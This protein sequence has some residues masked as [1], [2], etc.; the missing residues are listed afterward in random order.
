MTSPNFFPPIALDHCAD[1]P[2]YQQLFDMF[3]TAILEGRLRPGQRVPSTRSLSVELMISRT[4][5]LTAYEQLRAEGYLETFLGS[6]TCVAR[7]FPDVLHDL[8]RTGPSPQTQPRIRRVAQRVEAM[9]TDVGEPAPRAPGAFRTCDPALDQLPTKVWAGLIARHA[10]STAFEIAGYG[11]PMG[12]FPL[13]QSIAAY[14]GAVRATSCDTS[15]IMIVSGSQQGLQ[16]TAQALLNSGDCVWLEDPGY[17]RAR[18]T[19]LMAG[20]APAPIPV[21]A[22]GL[23]V[24]AGVQCH[25]DACAAYVTPS[26]QN[27]TGVTMSAGRRLQLLKWAAHAGAWII[28]DDYDSE[29]RYSGRPIGSIRGLD[30]DDRV[31]YLGT[32]SKVLFPALRLGYLVIPRNLVK[33]FLCVRETTDIFTPTLLQAVLADFIQEGHFARHTRRMRT[34]YMERAKVLTDAISAEVGDQ[35]EVV[36]AEAGMHL[37][38]LL[39][40]GVS[41]V[42]IAG[43]AA[44]IGLQVSPLSACCIDPPARAGLILGFGAVDKLQ[45]R[46]A[47]RQLAQIVHSQCQMEQPRARFEPPLP[48]AV[49]ASSLE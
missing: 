26:H 32:F 16:I 35:L 28:E 1:Q 33:A 49:Q 18:R 41:D 43:R 30:Q 7:A 36:S 2:L 4:S 9:F 31:I 38:A 13:R 14:L 21:D 45:I 25:P 23:V 27:P 8:D 29:F 42:S 47:V 6:G 44:S 19:L 37:T 24:Q 15:Q 22:E 11:D 46:T 17:L 20:L 34:I 10:R 3:Q 5:V 12:Y 40:P 39:P 48:R